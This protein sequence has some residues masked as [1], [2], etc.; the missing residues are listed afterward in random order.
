MP[1][2]MDRHEGITVPPEELY[3]AH[4]M[5]LEAQA[6]HGVQ[7]LTYWHDQ[8]RGTVFCLVEAP[9]RDAAEAVHRDSHGLTASDIIPV[10]DVVVEAFLGR[11]SDPPGTSTVQ[12]IADS[13]FRTIVFTDLEGSTSL[14]QRIGDHAAMDFLREHNEIVREALRECS[15]SEVK[16]TGDGIM[17]SFGS[18]TRAVESAIQIQRS[19]HERNENREAAFRV[20]VGLSA[21]EPVCEHGDLFGSAVQLARR[22]C[23]YAEPGR[24]L[25]ANVVRELCIGKSFQFEDRGE[26]SLKGFADP[27]RVHEVTWLTE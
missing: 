7:Y 2:F 8:S 20:R 16:H 12:P 22:V 25:A 10:D 26:A 24:I 15:G 23:D 13:A 5:D 1:K 4:L 14:T 9:S 21:G 19:F 17:A 6:K 18:A 3:S 11:I 27:V